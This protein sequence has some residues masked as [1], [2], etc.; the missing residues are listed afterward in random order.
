MATAEQLKR[1]WSTNPSDLVT[2]LTL[3]LAGFGYAGL[4]ESTV[5]E[6]IENHYA[7]KQPEGVIAMFVDEWLT[8]GID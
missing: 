7:G 1:V 4:E 6:A 2:A 5:K 3:S 8:K